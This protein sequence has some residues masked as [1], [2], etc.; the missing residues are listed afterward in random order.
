MRRLLS[1]VGPP[2]QALRAVLHN[3]PMTRMQCAFLLFNVAEPAM[4][5]GVL[6]FAFDI[7]G[8]AAVGFVTLLCCVPAGILAPAAAALGDRFRRDRVV[9]A[10]Y[11]VQAVTTAV[12]A[13]AIAAGAPPW[14]VY[15]LALLASIPYTTGRPNHHAI[16]PSLATTPEEVAASNSVS[17]LVEGIGYIV[18]GIGAAL[19]A[20][21]GPG[22]IVAEAAIAC[23][24]AGLLTL[25]VRA[26]TT[27]L[28]GE[29]F[30]PWSLATDA[31]NGLA[32]LIRAR[33]PRL[34]VAIA[35]A[36]AI[37]TGAAGVLMVPLAIDRLE[38]GDPGVGLLGTMQSVGLFLGAGVSVAFATRR[39]LAVGIIV[40]AAIFWLG[41]S[42][43]GAAASVAVAIVAAVAYGAGIT[44]LDVV[45]RTMLQRSTSDEVL[46]RVFGA[47][48]GLWL[49]G[50]AAGAT[51]APIAQHVVGLGWAFAILGGLVFVVVAVSIPA[52][53]GLDAAAVVPER[54]RA[55]VAHV[56]FFAPLPPFDLERIARQLDLLAVTTGTEVIR[57]GDVG[58]RF[59]IVDA[60]TFEIEIDGRRIGTVGSGGFF[61]EIAL[62]HDVPRTATVRALTDGAVWALD[63]EEFVATVTGLPQ[64]R[65]A[66]HELSAE[67]LRSQPQR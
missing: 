60:G 33:G 26:H 57:E 8:T 1:H 47:V 16:V 9:R 49:L 27:E 50:Y 13:T 39:K 46:T 41:T 65:N 21:I 51:L 22:A 10:G 29:T 18:G 2:L 5:I 55:L 62:L 36:L 20:T 30:H 56:P 43:L 40:A 63:Q 19:L 3:R 54:Q 44:L 14:A 11:L 35:A 17:A 45:G 67:R 25:G 28:H 59:Y 31:I 64:A 52:L 7:G 37:G 53:R 32:T 12:L 58:D 48:E 66:A 23:L 38:L 4:W 42:G 24:L 15:A 6:L 34:L 61:G